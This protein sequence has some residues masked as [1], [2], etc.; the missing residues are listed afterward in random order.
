MSRRINESESFSLFLPQ[1]DLEQDIRQIIRGDG[2]SGR[3]ILDC[4]DS[5]LLRICA[6]SLPLSCER[7]GQESHHQCLTAMEDNLA[8]FYSLGKTL[9]YIILSQQGRISILLSLSCSEPSAVEKVLRGAYPGIL[10]QKIPP[11]PVALG[12][13]RLPFCAILQGVPTPKEEGQLNRL[14]HGLWSSNWAYVILAQPLDDRI[15]ISTL[16]TLSQEQQRLRNTFLRPLT[17]EQDNNPLAQY[18][19]DLLKATFEQYRLGHVQG[20]W[21]TRG[22]FFA[23]SPG[24]LASG[25][26]ILTSLFCGDKSVP[27]PFRAYPCVEGK[28]PAQPVV[29]NT[30]RL[31]LLVQ[32]PTVEM[33][34]YEVRPLVS[35]ASA[36]PQRKPERFVA[37]GKVLQQNIPT[38]DWW[39]V[40][41]NDFTKHVLVTGV[42]GSGKTETCHFI[43]DQLWRENGIPYL[44]IEPAKKEYRNLRLAP[45]H[46]GLKVFALGSAEGLPLHLNPFEFARGT[47]V[48][49]HIDSLRSLFNA[50]FAGL[51]PPMPYI[52]EEALYHVYQKGGWDIATGQNRA[53]DTFPTVNDFCAEVEDIALGAGYDRE[54]TQNVSTSLR[55]RLNSLRVGAKGLILN[56]GRSTSFEEIFASP[57]VIELSRLGDPEA[58]AFIMGLLLVR[59]YEHLMQK[60]SAEKLCHVTLIEEAHRLFARGVDNSGDIEVSHI[61]G[62]AVET[63]SNMLMEVRA[64]G[65]GFIIVDQSPTKLHPDAIKGTNLKI[66]HRLVAEDDRR[67]IGGSTNMTDEQE[68]F[69][70]TLG[71]GVAAVYAEGFYQ[72][73]LV[74]VPAFRKYSLHP[75]GCTR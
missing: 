58:I 34:G 8:G 15:I 7:Q 75:D 35:F 21:E 13:C 11:Q 2:P 70:A 23:D 24:T 69:L 60:N 12:I 73:Y 64:Y 44:V 32:L 65:E 17:T 31:S 67:A 66:V 38:E 61:R 43:L 45:G 49:T 42:T 63:F 56:A 27:V 18:Y 3:P 59:L 14:L 10:T 22:A 50:S 68:G 6:I 62:Q 48:Q 20:C 47:H 25:M 40:S 55:V 29:L 28:P 46:E 36:L 16:E 72:P 57:T 9:I 26:A 4:L 30:A 39:E 41:L 37:I 33:P 74:E 52:L 54:T 53:G 5:P 19:L 71:T 1:G 51:Y